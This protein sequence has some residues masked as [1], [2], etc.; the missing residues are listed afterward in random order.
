VGCHSPLQRIFPAQGSNPGLLHGRQILYRLSHQGRSHKGGASQKS[1]NREPPKM[2]LI[3]VYF[4]AIL[5]EN[6]ENCSVKRT[7]TLETLTFLCTFLVKEDLI[8]TC[9][10]SLPV[11]EVPSQR[12]AF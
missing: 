2:A 7:L 1:Q 10:R 8:W 9:F 6:L 12:K 3:F 11:A 5:S 4:S